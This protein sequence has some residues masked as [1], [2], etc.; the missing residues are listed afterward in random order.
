MKNILWRYVCSV[1]FILGGLCSSVYAQSP[2]NRPP[3]CHRWADESDAGRI[4]DLLEMARQGNAQA[5]FNLATCYAVARKFHLAAPWYRKAAELGMVEA[6][7][8]VGVSFEEGKGVARDLQQAVFWYRKAAEQGFPNAQ[9]NLAECYDQGKGIAQDAKQAVSWYR[10]AAEQGDAAA[11]F[12]L[13]VSYYEGKGV[14]RN[15]DQ[16]KIWFGK[17]GELASHAPF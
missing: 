5:Q 2:Q 15:V 7:Y 11:S 8:N 13:G 3:V 14:A 16:A 6:Q 4:T 17:A 9:Y 10:K 12:A 1:I